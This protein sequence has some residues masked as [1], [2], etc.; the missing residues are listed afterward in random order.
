MERKNNFVIL[1]TSY[2]DEAWVEYNLASILNQTYTN[3]K[4]IYIDDASQD[5]TYE[6]ALNLIKNNS[7]FKITKN[8]SNKG[9]LSSF[10]SVI[11]DLSDDDIFIHISGDDWLI[12]DE[13]LNKLNDFYNTQ[14]VWMTYGKFFTWKDSDTVT[15]AYPQNTP[16]PDFIHNSKHY[17]KDVW[18]AS[19]LRTFRGF[20]LKKVDVKDFKSNIDS[21]YYDHASDLAVSFPCLEM[22]GKDKIGVVDFPTYVYNVSPTQ[23]NRTLN[24]EHN[25]DSRLYESE[26]RNKKSYKEGLTGDKLPQI[27]VFYDYME[28]WTVPKKFT[29]C[30]EQ[31]DGEFDM[32]FIG[33]D[34][35]EKYLKGEFTIKKDVPIVARLLEHRFYFQDRI[36]NLVKNNYEKFHTIFTHDK[37]LLET[38]P[39]AKFMPATDVIR[40]NML[41]NPYNQSPFK[42]LSEFPSY[43]MPED[44][45]QIYPKNKLVS[46]TAS[47]KAFLP[48]HRERLKMLES[49]KDKVDMF[50]SIQL[51]L[52]GKMIRDERKFESLKDYA[53]SIAI[54]NL[55]HEVDDYYF[56][57]K[58]TDCFIT[59][60][61]PIYYGCPNIGKF[62]NTDGILIFNTPEELNNILDNLSMDLYYSKI[63]A[64]KDNFERSLKTNLTNDLA[65][66]YYFKNIIEN[67]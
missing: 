45:F 56:S 64:V 13:V 25:T 4:V 21:K 29:Y 26:I 33:D 57:E 22:C 11:K 23:Q 42:A 16:Y 63:E 55:S 19:H 34:K 48:G 50:G 31:S 2:N 3:Y 14:D 12:D 1:V 44:I 39:N 67:L 59:G 46:V 32:V 6:K 38:L 49:V 66:E 10:V 35:I 54:E 62:F 53:F 60:T 8:V 30:Y 7:K 47:N 41:P 51:Y 18:R 58:I 61:I 43:E 9:A 65:Y 27:N 15:E 20:L 17:R 24:R 5:L 37:E 36:F 40:F 28:Y 52:Y